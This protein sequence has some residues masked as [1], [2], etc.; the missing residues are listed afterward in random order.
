M[1]PEYQRRVRTKP[2][3]LASLR[4]KGI[5]LHRNA[6]GWYL[7]LHGPGWFGAKC[8]TDDCIQIEAKR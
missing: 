1:K 5:H 8:D 3:T 4:A 6:V 2:G 7:L